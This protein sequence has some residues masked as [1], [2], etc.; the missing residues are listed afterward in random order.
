MK[1]Q[2]IINQQTCVIWDN[3]Q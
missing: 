1:Q 3:K 2:S